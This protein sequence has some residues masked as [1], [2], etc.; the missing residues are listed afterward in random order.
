MAL[1]KNI[2]S[3]I[4]K[5]LERELKDYRVEEIF[6]EH[7][8]VIRATNDIYVDCRA[9]L[10]IHDVELFI[11]IEMHRNDPVH[12]YLKTLMW[13]DENKLTHPV[14]LL[15]VFDVAYVA[16]DKPNKDFC[17]FLHLKLQANYQ[18]LFTY[19]PM[20]LSGLSDANKKP[21]EFD[22]KVVADKIALMAKR[23]VEGIHSKSK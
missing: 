17:D 19:K 9:M 14:A 10:G 13:L 7:P 21:P 6:F 2:K 3:A 5:A 16:D 1:N 15:H 4:K 23:I 22:P 18:S 20:N 12:N 8:L 11:E